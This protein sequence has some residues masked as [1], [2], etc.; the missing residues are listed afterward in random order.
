MIEFEEVFEK[1]TI[2]S[3]EAVVDYK[4]KSYFILIGLALLSCG[5]SVVILKSSPTT[6]VVDPAG[7]VSQYSPYYNKLYGNVAGAD[8]QWIVS[9]KFAYTVTYQ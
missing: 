8:I 4:M 9:S 5:Y 7:A 3:L 6:K 2:N 1:G